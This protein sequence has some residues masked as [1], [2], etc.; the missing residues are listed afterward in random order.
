M[1]VGGAGGSTDDLFASALGEVGRDGSGE[2]ADDGP[3]PSLLALHGRP[4][5]EV[6]D[7]AARLLACDDP[8]ER[9]LGARVLRELGPYGTEG[10][11]P[12]TAE[13]IDVVLAEMADEPDPE[14]LGWMISVLGYHHA[15]RALDLVLDHQ[16]HAEQPVRFAVAAALP[17]M[18]DPDRTQARVVDA[19]L[20]LAGD[21]HD[22]VRWYALYALFNETAGITDERK[23]LWAARLRG[24]ADAQRRE[25]LA[26]LATTLD[27]RADAALRDLLA[28]GERE[29]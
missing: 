27:D 24:R 5:R 14:V 17:G 7:R 9:E 23:R 4:T 3:L 28:G 16:A 25:E 8:V 22:A 26:Q 6:F 19:L 13:T 12:F 10:R 15:R 18:A 11:R 20:R 2:G 1:G 29:A 21:D